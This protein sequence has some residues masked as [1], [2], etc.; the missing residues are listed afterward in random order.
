MLNELGSQLLQLPKELN[1]D[2]AIHGYYGKKT[3]TLDAVY[4]DHHADKV[5]EVIKSLR[6]GQI[7]I[8]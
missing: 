7:S 4:S 8:Y 5:Q 2:F 3:L 1:L 6:P